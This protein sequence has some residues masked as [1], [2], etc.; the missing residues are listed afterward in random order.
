LP[1]DLLPDDLLPDDLPAS[2]WSTGRHLGLSLARRLA[3]A[4]NGRLL[5]AGTEQRTR[6]T[7]LLPAADPPPDPSPPQPSKSIM[8]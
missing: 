8:Q 1:D 7:L 3:E 6:L 5:H 2:S 4:E